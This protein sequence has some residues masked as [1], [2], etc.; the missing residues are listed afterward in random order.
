MKVGEKVL[1]KPKVGMFTVVGVAPRAIEAF[2]RERW[3][4][5]G[6]GMLLQ[7]DLVS[8]RAAFE[9]AFADYAAFLPIHFVEMADA[10][11]LPETGQYDPAGLPQIRIGHVPLIANPAS[12]TAAK[13][14]SHPVFVVPASPSLS[15]CLK[16]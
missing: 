14:V 2:D 10:G 4:D 5:Y 9:Q 15:D 6:I 8:A 16:A 7:G 11:P 1:V 12:M 3:N 13:N